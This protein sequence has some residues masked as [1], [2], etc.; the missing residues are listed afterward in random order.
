M[1]MLHMEQYDMGFHATYRATDG[2]K[3]QARRRIGHLVEH[4]KIPP[5]SSLMCKDCGAAACDYDHHLGYG[6][7]HHEDVEPVCKD[8]HVNR[9][10]SRGNHF[11]FR[12]PW[13]SKCGIEPRARGQR[14]CKAHH[15]EMERERRKTAKA[16]RIEGEFDRFVQQWYERLRPTIDCTLEE[17]K[18]SIVVVTAAEVW[19]D[20]RV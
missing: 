16:K 12:A 5:A 19:Q 10:I 18:A 13:C 7:T 9:E 2:N 11:K 4:G 20:G 1:K 3:R 17:F 8:C 15:N 14:Y 6:A